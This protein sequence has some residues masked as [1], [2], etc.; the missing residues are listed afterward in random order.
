MTPQRRVPVTSPQTR[1]AIARRRTGVR[2]DP[3]HLAP[4]ELD[5]ARR[6]H[7]LQLR[8]ALG[9][10]TLLA[11]LLLGVPPLLAALP[12]LD[13]LRVAGIPLSWLVVAVAPYPVLALLA[14]WQLYRAEEAERPPGHRR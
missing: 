1:L 2:I 13:A 3:P 5:L 9:A 11:A 10:L 7:R 8:R 12:A 4:A 6:V 14:R